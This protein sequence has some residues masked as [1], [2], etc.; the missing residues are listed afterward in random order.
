MQLFATITADRSYSAGFKY[1][2]VISH[3]YSCK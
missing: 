1:T 2:V 3:W